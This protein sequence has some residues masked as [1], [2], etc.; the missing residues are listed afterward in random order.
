ALSSANP[1]RLF[2]STADLRAARRLEQ[3]G[4]RHGG[5]HA[6]LPAAVVEG[7]DRQARLDPAQALCRVA[8]APS[9]LRVTRRKLLDE[10][11]LGEARAE[12]RAPEVV[13]AVIAPALRGTPLGAALAAPDR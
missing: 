9:T 7:E 4:E 2:S 13:N 11:R 8:R 3:V 10:G 12:T 6:G 5:A 1:H